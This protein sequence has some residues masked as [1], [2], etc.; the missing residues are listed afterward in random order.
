MALK[1]ARREA[2]PLYTLSALPLELLYLLLLLSLLILLMGM[3][4]NN[5]DFGGCALKSIGNITANSFIKEGGTNQQYSM[6][7]G[8]V[9]EL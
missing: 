4:G 3:E 1:P 8:S 9:V 7:D 6:A 5:F 2:Q